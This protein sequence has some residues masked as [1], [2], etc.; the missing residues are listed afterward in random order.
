MTADEIYQR[1]AQIAVDLERISADAWSLERERER[2]RTDLRRAL[3]TSPNQA[4]Q[5]QPGDQSQAQALTPVE[6]PEPPEIVTYSAA[7]PLIGAGPLPAPAGPPP[8][9]TCY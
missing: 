5:P 8:R 2:L 6:R 7:Q 3:S 1:L 4:P 9:R